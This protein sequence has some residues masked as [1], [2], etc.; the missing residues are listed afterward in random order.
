MCLSL[1]TIKRQHQN[2]D[3]HILTKI[4][5]RHQRNERE[6]FLSIAKKLILSKQWVSYVVGARNQRPHKTKVPNSNR[7]I[8]PIVNVLNWDVRHSTNR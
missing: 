3:E 4:F 6:L 5:S 1:K 2:H 8:S 7:C